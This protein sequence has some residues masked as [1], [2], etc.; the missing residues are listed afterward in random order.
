VTD[1]V[2]D[3]SELVGLRWAHNGNMEAV[4]Q[5]WWLGWPPERDREAITRPEARRV[6]ACVKHSLAHE[7]THRAKDI[8]RPDRF[9]AGRRAYERTRRS[10]SR[11]EDW[12]VQDAASATAIARGGAKA[13]LKRTAAR[14]SAVRTN[15]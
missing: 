12:P 2:L 13:E 10:S 11:H 14:S 6:Y 5:T 3:H 9:D 7:A 15:R 1:G 4:S 8:G